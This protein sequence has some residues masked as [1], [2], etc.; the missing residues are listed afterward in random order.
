MLR[1][2]RRGRSCPPR[3]RRSARRVLRRDRA[4]RVSPRLRPHS[5]R[6]AGS[7]VTAS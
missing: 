1:H 2:R 6:A 4:A 3:K 5:V 7:S